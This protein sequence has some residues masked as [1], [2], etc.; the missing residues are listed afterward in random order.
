MCVKDVDAFKSKV[1]EARSFGRSLRSSLGP[2]CMD[3]IIQYKEGNSTVINDGM[4]YKADN[5]SGK[6]TIVIISK[7]VTKYFLLVHRQ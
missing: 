6:K 2:K 7:L 3:K 4:V 1:V 5:K